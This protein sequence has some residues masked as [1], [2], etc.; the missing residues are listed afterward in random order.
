MYTNEFIWFKNPLEDMGKREYLAS[1]MDQLLDLIK[2]NKY[3]VTI[4]NLL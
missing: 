4:T 2:D 3:E 1:L